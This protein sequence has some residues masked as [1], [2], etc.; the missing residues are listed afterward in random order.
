MLE[1]IE[2]AYA[3]ACS[4]DTAIAAVGRRKLIELAEA[5]HYAATI[6][7]V[8]IYD[9]HSGGIHP[10]PYAVDNW[11]NRARSLQNSLTEGPDLSLAG[12]RGLIDPRLA[13]PKLE[14]LAYLESACKL[15]VRDAYWQLYEAT[16]YENPLGVDRTELLRV[17]AENF[18]SP[19]LV[20]FAVQMGSSDKAEL[21]L[22]CASELGSRRAKEMLG[23]D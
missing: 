21:A 18:Y 6:H 20:E 11:I 14:A 5:G 16:R 13:L 2:D 22:R 17:A 4:Q 10:D 3:L 9:L 7:L 19:A 15:G 8:D 12:A 23:E 1:V